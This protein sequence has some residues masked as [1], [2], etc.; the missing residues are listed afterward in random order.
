VKPAAAQGGAAFMYDGEAVTERVD[1]GHVEGAGTA[2]LVI[3]D[4]H[5]YYVEVDGAP[6]EG[7]DAA[8]VE[9]AAAKAVAAK[10]GAP[11]A[12]GHREEWRR[13]LAAFAKG[14][15]RDKEAPS[16]APSDLEERMALGALL[17]ASG[18]ASGALRRA[19]RDTEL[20]FDGGRVPPAEVAASWLAASETAA[21]S[22]RERAPAM[23]RAAR[24]LEAAREAEA[25][26]LSKWAEGGLNAKEL[27]GLAEAAVWRR[28]LE[29]ELTALALDAEGRDRVVQLSAALKGGEER[30]R[31]VVRYYA[32]AL[33]SAASVAARARDEAGDRRR[34][35]ALRSAKVEVKGAEA[36][37]PGAYNQLTVEV[38]LPALAPAGGTVEAALSLPSQ[39][40]IVASEG[41]RLVRGHY[42]LRG[43]PLKP[44]GTLTW[45]VD[46]Y[47]PARVGEETGAIEVRIGFAEAGP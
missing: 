7:K 14:K 32:R 29:A 39:L 35:A 15:G 45:K 36:I 16:G 27:R 20:A 12:V 38:S 28:A 4:E 1:L 34:L 26:A 42:V 17:S 40:W 2:R 5:G 33:S 18:A 23:A 47:V 46:L 3:T 13:V 6:V 19:M 11:P 25:A 31:D 44:G 24:A 43:A 8:A 10:A 37:V 9:R 30:L 41:A 21:K 22:Q